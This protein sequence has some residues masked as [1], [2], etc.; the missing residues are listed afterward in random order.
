MRLLI[1]SCEETLAAMSDHLDGELPPLQRYRVGLHLH[2]C[3]LCSPVYSSL[4]RT[5]SLL[6]NTLAP[7]PSPAFVDTVVARVRGERR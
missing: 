1:G 7:E 6:R 2:V 4:R 3:K 5:V